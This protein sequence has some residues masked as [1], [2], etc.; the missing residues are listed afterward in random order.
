[1]A[2]EG[3]ARRATSVLVTILKRDLT[4]CANYRTVAL[5][6]HFSKNSSNDTRI[7]GY[8][9]E[10]PGGFRTVQQI[11]T[12]RLIASKYLERGMTR[13]GMLGSGQQKLTALTC[14]E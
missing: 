4:D 6:T 11:I 8:L 10:K 3:V 1:M 9:S 14:T 12:L 7:A 13:Y 2:R 5:I